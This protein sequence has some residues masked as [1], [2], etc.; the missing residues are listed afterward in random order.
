MRADRLPAN[1]RRASG[2]DHFD[3]TLAADRLDLRFSE[4]K[5]G[6]EQVGGKRGRMAGTMPRPELTCVGMGQSRATLPLWVSGALGTCVQIGTESS[7]T[8]HAGRNTTLP[9]GVSSRTIPPE[10]EDRGHRHRSRR[11]SNCVALASCDGRSACSCRS[12]D[13]HRSALSRLSRART[14]DT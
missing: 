8:H 11:R 1:N 12:T 7:A 14:R 13:T 9:L 5:E 6:P 4:R 10:R 2:I 3:S